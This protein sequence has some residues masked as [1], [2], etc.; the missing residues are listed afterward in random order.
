VCSSGRRHTRFSRDWSS[1]VCSSDLTGFRPGRWTGVI[2]WDGQSWELVGEDVPDDF[3][4][5]GEFQGKLIATGTSGIAEWDGNAWSPLE[6][7]RTS[8]RGREWA[9]CGWRFEYKE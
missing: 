8:G 5:L 7:G 6:I 1:D 9:T 4:T 3:F 2:K